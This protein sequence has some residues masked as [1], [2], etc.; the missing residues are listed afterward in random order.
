M[1]N[2]TFVMLLL[3]ATLLFIPQIFSQGSNEEFVDNVI[4]TERLNLNEISTTEKFAVV[5]DEIEIKLK[6]RNRNV[7]KTRKT[8]EAIV[9]NTS[10]NGVS[11]FSN[12]FRQF[13]QINRITYPFEINI[14]DVS[15]EDE[16]CPEICIV[17]DSNVVY[18]FRL[19]SKYSYLY[20][21]VQESN[22]RLNQYLLDNKQLYVSN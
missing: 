10:L 9:N 17:V 5:L 22:R 16:R 1:N 13:N 3:F 14:V 6:T 12:L 19:L 15:V 11:D 2:N 18:K 21:A 8:N 7:K 4:S 20:A